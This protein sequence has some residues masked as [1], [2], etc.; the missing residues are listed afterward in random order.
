MQMG[1]LDENDKFMQLPQRD[2]LD[3]ATHD[4]EPHVR[5]QRH[6][7]FGGHEAGVADTRLDGRGHRAWSCGA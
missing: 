5:E 1:G 6:G 3:Y 7:L 2:A 4:T